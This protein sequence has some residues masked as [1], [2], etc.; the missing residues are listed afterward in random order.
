MS[1]FLENSKTSVYITIR[2]NDTIPKL[3]MLP[4]HDGYDT[5]RRPNTS[6]NTGGDSLSPKIP[7]SESEVLV[8]LIITARALSP[9][10]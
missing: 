1:V 5:T 4:N 7:S 2:A 10:R 8:S 9:E 3:M 6:K